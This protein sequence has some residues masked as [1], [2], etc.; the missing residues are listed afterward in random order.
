[1]AELEALAAT[2]Y[3][4]EVGGQLYPRVLIRPHGSARETRRSTSGA[5]EGDAHMPGSI[6]VQCLER[7]RGDR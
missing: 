7:G 1:M 6:S 3:L 5:A 4:D 2:L